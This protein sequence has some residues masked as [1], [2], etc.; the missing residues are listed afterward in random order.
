MRVSAQSRARPMAQLMNSSAAPTRFCNASA[1][2]G[3]NRSLGA[4][5][6]IFINDGGGEVHERIVD[7]NNAALTVTDEY[8]TGVNG[9]VLGHEFQSRRDRKVEQIA[10]LLLRGN[11]FYECGVPVQLRL[12]LMMTPRADEARVRE[13]FVNKLAMHRMKWVDIE[14]SVYERTIVRQS[15]KLSTIQLVGFVGIDQNES[16]IR[17]TDQ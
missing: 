17:F 5:A 2:F 10:K 3:W 15:H 6:T 7:M 13:R 8:R 14:H 9:L 1:N 16:A 4:G 11:V 12:S